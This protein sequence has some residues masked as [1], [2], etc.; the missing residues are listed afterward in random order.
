MENINK[1]LGTGP[2]K[3]EWNNAS[4]LL[5]NYGF[6]FDLL[7]FVLILVVGLAFYPGVLNIT[8]GA[9]GFGLGA[10]A[11]LA[12]VKYGLFKLRYSSK[13]LVEGEILPVALGVARNL[14]L[15]QAAIFALPALGLIFLKFSEIFLSDIYEDAV[16]ELAVSYPVISFSSL[17]FTIIFL[18][19]I[20]G[21]SYRLLKI[22]KKLV[23][24]EDGVSYSFPE[25]LKIVFR[26]TRRFVRSLFYFALLIVFAM[27]FAYYADYFINNINKFL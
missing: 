23:K 12:G 7:L 15:L 9:A 5:F 17:F 27:A 13:Y 4:R 22:D 11:F 25:A 21:G 18:F 26:P 19:A 16:K 2:T 6:S 1:D 20:F 8:G 14:L 10:I 24:K 3:E